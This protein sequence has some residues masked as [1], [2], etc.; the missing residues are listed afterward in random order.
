MVTLWRD[1][2]YLCLS[3]G[4]LSDRRR[5]IGL[6]CIS[7]FLQSMRFARNHAEGCVVV[8]VY[9]RRITFRFL[10][11]GGLRE[12]LFMLAVSASLALGSL[13]KAIGKVLFTMK[14]VS[15]EGTQEELGAARHISMVQCHLVQCYSVQC[16][17]VRHGT[18]ISRVCQAG[19]GPSPSFGMWTTRG[20]FFLAFYFHS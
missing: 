18:T 16:Y 17:F 1:A 10:L 20:F 6:S 19:C 9:T 4:L 3:G 13:C 14:S 2:G 8:R 12:A 11:R 7:V 5:I 15:L